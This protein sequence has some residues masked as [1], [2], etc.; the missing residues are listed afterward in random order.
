MVIRCTMMLMI[1][2]ADRHLMA[3]IARCLIVL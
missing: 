2:M 3:R 1:E